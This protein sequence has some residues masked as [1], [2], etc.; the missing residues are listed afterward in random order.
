MGYRISVDTGGTFTDVVVTTGNGH[1]AGGKALTTP[2][3][4]FDGLSASL[5]NAAD[6]LGIEYSDLV[7]EAEVLIYGT[8]RATNAIV[9][10]DTAKTAFLTTAGFPDTL[11]YR[12]GGK[13]KPFDLRSDPPEPYIPRKLTFE[14]AERVDAEGGIVTALDEAGA[15]A[16]LAG[17]RDLDVEA[18]AV[19]L[20]WSVAN[21]GHEKRL[22]ELIAEEL[23][24]VPFT[25]SHQ[26][27]PVI[28]EYPRASSTCI[29]ASLKPLM[30]KHLRD[31]RTDLQEAGFGGELLISASSGGVVHVADVIEKPVLLVKSG[32]SMAPL[33]GIAVAKDEAPGTDDILVVDTGGTTFDVSLVRSGQVKY[34]RET[35][36]G[37]VYTGHNVGMSSVDI[38]SVGAGGGS[39]AWVDS[40]GLLK[41]GPRS[42]G[43][44]PGPAAYGLGGTEPTVT[45]ASVVLGYIDPQ[46]FL[47]G[48]MPLDAAA[49]RA[50]VAQVAD[51][52]GRSVEEAAFAILTLANE[53][54][55]K[56]IEEITVNDG[57]D[58][59]ESVL[60]A[61]GGAAG[62]NILPIAGAL[63]CRRVVVPKFAGTLTAFG[64]QF[65][66]IVSEFS[67][68]RLADSSRWDFAS[69]GGALD[70]VEEQMQAFMDGLRQQGVEEFRTEYF[71]D[72]RYLNQ[73]W[74][75]EIRTPTDGVRTPDDVARLVA[76]FHETHE[77]LYGVRE[78]DGQ[79]ECLNWK[80]RVT[81]KVRR[82][83]LRRSRQ[84]GGELRPDR[85]RQAWFGSDAVETPVY[86]GADLP[87]GET[88]RGPAII[89][90]PTTTVVIYP[91]MT[92]H[93]SENGNYVLDT[94]ASQAQ[95]PVSGAGTAPRG[96]DKGQ[97][98][99]VTLAVMANRL[100][101]ILREMSSII[102]RTARSAVIGQSRDFSSAVISAD[103]RV[104]ATAEG[105]PAHIFGAHLQT[106]SMCELHPDFK[107]GDAFLHNDP[108]MGNSH[109]A[110]HTVLVPVFDDEGRHIFSLSC[111]G[112]QADCGNGIPSTYA[113]HA[114]DVYEEGAL[115]F[116]CV[117]VQRD[118]EDIDDIVRMCKR[119]IRI[120]D[121]WYGDFQSIMGALRV[122]EKRLHEFIRRYGRETIAQFIEE[123]FDYSERKCLES[124]RRMPAG[125]IENSLAHDPMPP[126]FDD[127]IRL[128][129]KIDIDPDAGKICVDLRDNPDCV[130]AGL[131][132][133]EATATVYG[134]QGT[135][136]CLDPDIPPNHGSFRRIEVKLRE[137]CCVGI[138]RFPA[139]CSAGTTNLGDVTVS[140]VQ[141]AYAKLGDGYGL[142]Q[143]NMCFGSGMGVLS[144][145]DFRRAD[146]PYI[147]QIY[148]QGGGGP[149]SPDTDGMVYLLIPVGAGLLFRDSVEFD[150]QR[151]PVHVNSM[152]LVPDSCGAGRQRGGPGTEVTLTTRRDPMDVG[153]LGCGVANPPIGV[154]GGHDGPPAALSIL[155]SNGEEETWEAGSM[156]QL[157]AGESFRTVD[158]GGGGYGDPAT[159]DPEKVRRDV[160]EK[161]VSVGQARDV[162]KVALTSTN[163]VDYSIDQEATATLRHP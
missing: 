34:S 50:A 8:T 79:I 89:E 5:K 116:P 149:A 17:L 11:V 85:I 84:T 76:A 3:R 102:L 12:Q 145:T 161:Y 160:E 124:I 22:G 119:R 121:Q 157:Q 40:G 78:A 137:N 15:R 6:N 36:L 82:P 32:P 148:L 71:V 83:Q 52:L 66:E 103:N 139:S 125:T 135:M 42:A 21:P 140:M 86:Q 134:L 123:W 117:Q 107:P 142:A 108:Y 147:N 159:R 25:L 7:A 29:D 60:V 23:P 153:V 39:I 68:S 90:E 62:I 127:E 144:G 41:V 136:H 2:G 53:T 77:R 26:L 38:R 92:G 133:T 64:A 13:L 95:T 69:V 87:A 106:R 131:N 120:P 19:C 113:A 99:P 110:D 143:G 97:L 67:C 61:G 91:G 151:F 154:Q 55:I 130:P 114:Q 141:T 33:A 27:N 47:G 105:L 150:E 152:R 37:P 4:S 54:M 162:Y 14:I 46:H 129:V 138:P 146:E 45:D 24:G 104:I 35:W 63:G 100:D 10:G 132:L 109:P 156:V 49:A 48:R 81:A 74:E 51:K 70:Q 88:I 75:T 94:V 43:S 56:A 30:Q 112:H 101:A 72:A 57:V 80:G 118:Y 31:L 98:D 73:H 126:V 9:T 158:S 44:V 122:A 59:A 115:I 65:S 18:V 1:I 111:K 163:G 93:V 20:L 16:T 28:R 96:Q 155:R 58:P 128:K